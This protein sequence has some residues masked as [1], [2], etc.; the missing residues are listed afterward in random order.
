MPATSR[1]FFEPL[2]GFIVYLTGI[3]IIFVSK[4]HAISYL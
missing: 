4:I 2:S 3:I 1:H